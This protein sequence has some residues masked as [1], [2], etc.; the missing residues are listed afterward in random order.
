MV[1]HMDDWVVNGF[2]FGL[3]D[4]AA[5][6]YVLYYLFIE[7]PGAAGPIASLMITGCWY[8]A[9]K[10]VDMHLENTMNIAASVHI[11]AWLAQFYGHGVHE[12]RS[13]ALLDNLFQAIFM[14]PLFVL[15]EVMF[16]FGYRKEFQE[17]IQPKIDAAILKF[18]NETKK[19]NK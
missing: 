19:K 7:Q 12:G 4:V 2:S 5:L 10:I 13:P 14:A 11:I 8:G 3:V 18:N 16:R 17:S 1:A 15:M 6:C 9:N